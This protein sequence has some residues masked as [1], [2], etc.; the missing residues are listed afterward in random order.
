ML[1]QEN[2]LRLLPRPFCDRSRAVVATWIAEYCIQFL[3][4]HVAKPAD[5]KFPREKVLRFAEQQ[6]RA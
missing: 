4:V 2:A 6:V 3:P 1:P 5:F